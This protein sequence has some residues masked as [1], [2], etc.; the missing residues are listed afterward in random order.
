DF[1][2]QFVTA[3]DNGLPP[4]NYQ[5]DPK[6]EL[7]HRTSPTNIGLSLAANLAAHDFGYVSLARVLDRTELT[8]ATLE[9][10]ERYRGHYFNWYDTRS[11]KPL[12][13]R[14]VSTVDSGNL[15]AGLLVLRQG[16]LEKARVPLAGSF[17]VE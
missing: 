6:S 5:E 2:E 10:L 15:F 3:D 11:L 13:P 8:L 1:F 4:D 7:A 14:Y 17:W 16:L 12:E 9:K